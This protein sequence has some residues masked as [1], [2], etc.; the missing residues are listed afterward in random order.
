MNEY[1]VGVFGVVALLG[2]A[3]LLSYK[4]SGDFATKIAFSVLLLY[5]VTVPVIEL[6]SNAEFSFDIEDYNP[7][8]QSGD[9][10]AVA[11]EAFEL[12]IK[13][14]VAE[15][16]SLDE[17][18]IRVLSEGFNFKKMKAEKIRIIL[19]GHSSLANYKAIEKYIREAGLGEC[20]VELEIG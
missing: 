2:T 14:A 18:K 5:T 8:N 13:R 9:Y 11:K 10:E 3:S 4:S 15:R 6:V 19:S 16:F 17:E 7:D 20:E 1:L 12:G